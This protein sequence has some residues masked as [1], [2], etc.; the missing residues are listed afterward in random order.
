[1]LGHESA[2]IVEAV[3]AEVTSVRP[4]DHVICCLSV[5][6]GQC[7][8]CL[9]GDTWL[10]DDKEATGRRPDEPPRLSLDGVEVHQFANV[11]G[12]AEQLLVHENATVAVTKEMP[13][14][15]A[16]PHRLRCHDRHRRRPPTPRG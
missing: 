9:T 3:G 11:S 12:F 8:N 7:R 13:L 14:D 2:G 4:G 16:A 5:F 15:R 6:C 10:C 1:M